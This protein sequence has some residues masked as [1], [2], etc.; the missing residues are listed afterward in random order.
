MSAPEHVLRGKR[1]L[2]EQLEQLGGLRNANPR[3]PSFKLWRQNT[4]TVLQRIWHGQ[5]ARSER[6]RQ[7]PFSPH[8]P[9]ADFATTREWYQRGC[10]EASEY[11]RALITEVES[12]GVP[13]PADAPSAEAKPIDDD[14][15]FPVLDLDGSSSP[16]APP[17]AKNDIVLLDKSGTAAALS[18]EDVTTPGP[19]PGGPAPP[20]LR[21]D[22]RNTGLRASA[23][24][25]EGPSIPTLPKRP[26][27]PKRPDSAPRASAP[28]ART[29]APRKSAPNAEPAARAKPEAPA[30]KRNGRTKPKRAP[31][32]T[33]PRLKDM[34]GLQDLDKS[35]GASKVMPRPTPPPAGSESSP[36]RMMARP[37]LPSSGKVEVKLPEPIVTSTPAAPA[38][39]APPAAEA[40]APVVTPPPAPVAPAPPVAETPAPAASPTPAPAAAAPEP[41]TA[42]ASAEPPATGEVPVFDPA[43]QQSHLDPEAFARA[44]EDFL[45]SSP[46]LGL[47]G[48]PV[49]RASD[50]T[51]FLDPD[52]VALATLASE[53]ARHVR[54]DAARG[55]LKQNLLD[56]AAQLEQKA[57]EW[58][59][60]RDT[61]AA[62]MA[63]PEL[64]KRL[65]PIVLP[66]L[67]RAA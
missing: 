54:E 28:S 1:W 8:S 57:P 17:A 23:R 26:E 20:T 55:P 32:A 52:A 13:N 50:T 12:V 65:M 45:R 24:D 47:Q 19:R 31:K 35:S 4:L 11:L 7:I 37:A 36:A 2:E 58:A 18:P 30:P 44:T 16:S 48:K 21:V 3:D 59:L 10:A 9:K 46:V 66:W 27:L 42:A 41:P 43:A 61:V 14:V 25:N 5:Q 40:P 39:P 22:V 53:I 34:L 67:G 64:A 15:D 38:P 49:Q 62:A 29:D 51:Q 33:P 60:L 56:L 63:H 6:F